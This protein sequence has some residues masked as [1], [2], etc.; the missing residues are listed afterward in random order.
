MGLMGPCDTHIDMIS[1]NPEK[2]HVSQHLPGFPQPRCR[3]LQGDL[4]QI[5]CGESHLRMGQESPTQREPHTW[6][7]TGRDVQQQG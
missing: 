3:L 1:E 7:L 2:E 6:A 5:P 4:A